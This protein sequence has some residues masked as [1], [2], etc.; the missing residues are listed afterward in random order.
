MIDHVWSVLCTRSVVDRDSNMISLLDGI[1]EVTA[2]VPPAFENNPVAIPFVYEIVS[3]WSRSDPALPVRARGRIRLLDQAG[4]QIGVSHDF[5]IDLTRHER[6][7]TQAKSAGLPAHGSG[8]YWF[9]V[10]LQLEER[11]EWQQVARLPLTL[12]IQFQAPAQIETPA[13]N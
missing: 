7:R 5:D 8:R 9:V 1:E 2:T 11:P 10:E 6:L 12:R 3:L 4:A 13:V